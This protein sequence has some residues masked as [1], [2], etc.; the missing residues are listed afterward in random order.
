[1][2][3]FLPLLQSECLKHILYSIQASDKPGHVL[4][5]PLFALGR[6]E[7]SAISDPSSLEQS[8]SIP[9]NYNNN[10]GATGSVQFALC[11]ESDAITRHVGHK[12]KALQVCVEK[13]E[14]SCFKVKISVKINNAF[15]FQ[16]DI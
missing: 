16:N 5:D 13:Q 1:M 11:N 14:M 15:V 4:N 12:L 7:V 3:N 2:I 8:A 9:K 10:D 6:D